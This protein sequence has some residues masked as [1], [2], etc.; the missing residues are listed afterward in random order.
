MADISIT[1]VRA[2][3]LVAHP[4]RCELIRGEI[5]TMSP[6]GDEHGFVALNI[7]G[8]LHAFVRQHPLGR[9]YAAE[10]GF[11]LERDPDTVRAPDVAFVSAAR[12]RRAEGT[13]WVIVA[14][15][16]VVEVVSPSESWS[17]VEAKT[18]WWLR[19]GVALIWLVDPKERTVEVVTATSRRTLVGDDRIDGGAE[20]PGFSVSIA[21][22]FA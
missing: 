19:H 1:L 11:W 12:Y 4:G 2:A 6:A 8:L 18:T 10:T 7:G 16:L 20:L 9:L 17:E 3:D 21:D 22:F 13:S 5:A 15:E 14:P